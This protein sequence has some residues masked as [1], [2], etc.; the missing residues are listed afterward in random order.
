[1]CLNEAQV[2]VPNV[3]GSFLKVLVFST[4]RHF[5]QSSKL[6]MRGYRNCLK[7]LQPNLT[8]RNAAGLGWIDLARSRESKCQR[9]TNSTECSTQ[10]ERHKGVPEAPLR[11]ICVCPELSKVTSEVHVADAAHHGKRCQSPSSVTLSRRR[12]SPYS[13]PTKAETSQMLPTRKLV[14]CRCSNDQLKLDIQAARLGLR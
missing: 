5:K 12:R 8:N 13:C 11:K 7:L 2:E 4:P 10:T 9:P 14:T 6:Q 3:S 1:M